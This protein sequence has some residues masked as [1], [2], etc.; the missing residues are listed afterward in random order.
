MSTE[1]D[2]KQSLSEL[3]LLIND[4]WLHAHFEDL[5]AIFHSDIVFKSPDFTQQLKGKTACIGSYQDFMEKAAI[6]SFETEAAQ[7]DIFGQTAVVSM[8]FS[9]RYI[10]SAKHFHKKGTDTFVFVKEAENWKAV[11]RGMTNLEHA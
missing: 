5:E 4:C 6:D 2:Q 8:N 1:I 3:M 7:I 9:M 11:W 10:I